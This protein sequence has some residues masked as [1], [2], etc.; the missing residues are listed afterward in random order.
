[1]RQHGGVCCRWGDEV[2]LL[3]EM[4]IRKTHDSTEPKAQFEC[5]FKENFSAIILMC[6]YRSVKRY[7][8]VGFVNVLL[9][10][11]AIR[12]NQWQLHIQVHA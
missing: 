4:Y 7:K 8:T 2:C 3:L 12:P 9:D 5:E 6:D 1:M 11:K 10:R